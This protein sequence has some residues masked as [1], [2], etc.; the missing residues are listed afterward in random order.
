MSG[1]LGC[2]PE[3]NSKILRRRERERQ[4]EGI[5]NTKASPHT[6]ACYQL[7]RKVFIF[8]EHEY[9]CF[10]SRKSDRQGAESSVDT[11]QRMGQIRAMRRLGLRLFFS[12]KAFTMPFGSFL[13]ALGHGVSRSW[14]LYHHNGCEGL[15]KDGFLVEVVFF[16]L[17]MVLDPVFLLDASSYSSDTKGNSF[18]P[19][20]AVFHCLVVFL[21]Q[22]W[23]GVVCGFLD[24]T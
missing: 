22:C 12:W 14:I 11:W 19:Y 24:A 16:S 2:F 9:A 15:F 17:V 8:D 4:R 5:T 1:A 20:L 18:D 13:L 7:Y 10:G 23:W 3:R 21:F 6:R